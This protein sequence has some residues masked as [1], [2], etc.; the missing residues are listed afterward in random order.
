[1]YKLLKVILPL[2]L[3]LCIIFLAGCTSKNV[4]DETTL[5]LDKILTGLLTENVELYK[6]AFSPDY[7]EKVTA[8]L[9][10]I[11]EDINIL[12]ANTIKDAI[13]VRNANYGEK[14]QINYVLISK[15]V[16]TTDDLKEPYW[17]NYDITYNLPVDKITEAY[18]ATF[19]IIYK[20]KESSET[21]RAE[22]KLLKIDGGWYLHPETFMN[23]FSG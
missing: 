19:D 13:D 6:S 3:I 22:Y 7:I 14:T 8:A 2:L 20:G 23:V 1:M 15:N 17:D 12:L 4:G 10:L 5:P 9:S 21:K 11:E 16:M 18:K